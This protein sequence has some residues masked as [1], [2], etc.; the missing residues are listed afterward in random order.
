MSNGKIGSPMRLTSFVLAAALVL[1]GCGDNASSGNPLVSEDPSS[2][3]STAMHQNAPVIVMLGDS[4]TAGFQLPAAAALPAA[5]QRDF[6]ARGVPA[7]FVNAG[8]SGDTTAD[9]LNRYEWSVEGANA[10]LLVVALGANDFLGDLP[11]DVPKR[12]LAAI[13]TKAKADNLPAVLI[14]VAIPGEAK[15]EREAAYAAIYPQLA[16]EFGVPYFPDMLAPVAGKP[17]LL[18]QDG[19]HPTS[20]GVE[21]MAGA[22]TGFLAPL[23]EDLS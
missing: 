5:L 21:A 10:D 23:V 17:G 2:D 6:E 13:L 14:G 12:N 20:E 7:R 15:D 16:S 11:A 19:V 22:I 3:T 18:Q 4:L 1:C 8:V 9:G